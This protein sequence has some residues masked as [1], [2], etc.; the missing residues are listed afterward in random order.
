[1]FEK[2]H[3]GSTQ[4]FNTNFPGSVVCPGE[5]LSLENSAIARNR[6]FL[7]CGHTQEIQ[8]RTLLENKKKRWR[9]NVERSRKLSRILEYIYIY[10]YIHISLYIYIYTPPEKATPVSYECTLFYRNL[11]NPLFPKSVRW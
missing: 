6:R 11:K 3:Q 9:P 2:R 7:H 4:K 5:L 10:I 1:M 8:E